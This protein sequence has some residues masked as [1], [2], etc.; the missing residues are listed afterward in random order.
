MNENDAMNAEDTS[1]TEGMSVNDAPADLSNSREMIFDY[2]QLAKEHKAH[3]SELLDKYTA[4]SDRG[5]SSDDSRK[6]RRELT[7]YFYELYKVIFFKSVEADAR[8]PNEV[9]MFLYF[10]YIDDKLAGE[11]NAKLLYSMAQN[12]GIDESFRVFPLYQW[13]RLIYIGKKDPSVNEFSLDYVA[14]LRQEKRQGNITAE[15]EARLLRNGKKRVEFEIDNMFKSANRMM[16]AR[17]TTF[18]P[19]FSDQNVYKPLEQILL[20]FEVLN[21]TVDVVKMID[22]SLFYRETVYA[23]PGIG[24]QKEVIQVEVLPDVI[25]MPCV[26]E[27]SAM[28]QEIAGAKRTTPARFC[29]PIFE[30]EELT[31]IIIKLCGEFRWELCR[32]IQ[33]ARWNDLTERSLTSDY[34]DYMDTYKRSRELSQEAKEK[35]K[36]S[37]VKHRNSS[38]EMFVE[39][40]IQYISFES[41]SA[42][43]L[44]KVSRQVLF[45]YCP[46]SKAIRTALGSNPQYQKLIEIYNNKNGHT[47]HLYSISLDRIKKAGQEVPQELRAHWMYLNM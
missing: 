2:A 3:L 33:G 9:M 7:A 35:I 16:T 34:C 26:G 29:L 6:L 41:Q 1:E 8:I 4:L 31:K 42:L 44:N 20:N 28:W 21:K 14:Y 17:V 22:Y 24:I 38:K 46:F 15:D 30:A 45:T 10:G 37:L 11:E 27:R 13:L 40:Y 39:D 5:D 43:R 23:N 19:F 47:R 25:L 32:R 36:G 18:C 12:I